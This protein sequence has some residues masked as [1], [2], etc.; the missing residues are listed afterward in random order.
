MCVS[1]KEFSPDQVSGGVFQ[2]LRAL[3]H[4]AARQEYMREG[5]LRPRLLAPHRER[6]ARLGLSL[7]EEMALL[8]AERLHA[9]DIGNI[10]V[11][12][13]DLQCD[14]QHFAENCRD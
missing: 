4:A 8:V 9:V 10:G 5:V 12:G 7:V 1:M 14:A 13:A 11:R 6:R 2:E 3:V